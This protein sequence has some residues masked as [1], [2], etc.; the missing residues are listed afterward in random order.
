MNIE[1]N[2]YFSLPILLICLFP[3]LLFY[4]QPTTGLCWRHILQINTKQ[5]YHVTIMWQDFLK[6][7]V[8][9]SKQLPIFFL[10]ATRNYRIEVYNSLNETVLTLNK[11]S[12]L[13]VYVHALQS[14]KNS[15]RFQFLVEF[16]Q[17]FLW[18]ADHESPLSNI[19]LEEYHHGSRPVVVA[20]RTRFK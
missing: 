3:N 19:V 10:N 18:L 9:K 8:I 17:T 16:L 12:Q 11:H 15:K 1:K 13:S 6:L 5:K 7:V 14:H 20:E 4:A 2:I